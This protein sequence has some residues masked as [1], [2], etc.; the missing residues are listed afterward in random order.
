M[1]E[2][3]IA[4]LENDIAE[5]ES[6]IEA[7]EQELIE[8]PEFSDDLEYQIQ[9]RKLELDDLKDELYEAERRDFEAEKRE[10]QR[11]WENSMF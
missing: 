11:E 3:I 6:E 8:Y 9:Q 2:E 1:N 4:G 7:L 5:K 10:E